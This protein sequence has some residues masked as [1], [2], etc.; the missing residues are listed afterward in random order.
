MNLDPNAKFDPHI[1]RVFLEGGECH[2]LLA[3][4]KTDARETANLLLKERVVPTPRVVE[5]NG[6]ETLLPPKKIQ[7]VQ[8]E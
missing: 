7:R 1:I 5:P 6:T 4:D 3:F 2:K 8:I